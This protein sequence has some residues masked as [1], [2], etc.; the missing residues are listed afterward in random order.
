MRIETQVVDPEGVMPTIRVSLVEADHAMYFTY[1]MPLAIF[2]EQ[3]THRYV[4]APRDI[5]KIMHPLE[6]ASP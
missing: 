6:I 2:K 4:L 5:M 1:E 3:A